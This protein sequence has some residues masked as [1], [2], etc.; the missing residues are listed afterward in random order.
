LNTGADKK[1][2][3]PALYPPL[4]LPSSAAAGSLR[5]SVSTTENGSCWSGCKARPSTARVTVRVAMGLNGSRSGS[6]AAR[7]PVAARR[8]AREAA[9][10]G[11][12][13]ALALALGP[14]DSACK[15]RARALLLL[16]LLLL[17]TLLPGLLLANHPGGGTAASM[18][19]REGGAGKSKPRTLSSWGE[20]PHCTKRRT[21]LLL[22]L[23][24]PELLRALCKRLAALGGR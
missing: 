20:T 5:G 8:E 10:G 21:C 12:L 7:G 17:S 13:L 19:E 18:S 1:P 14:P 9:R 15:E 11:A 2:P 24:L 16:L 23:T 3:S 22:L 4:A 6:K